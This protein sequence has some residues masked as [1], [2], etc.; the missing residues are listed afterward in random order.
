MATGVELA[1]GWVRVVPT[2]EGITPAI[3]KGLAPAQ[4]I[5]DVEGKKTGKR[6]AGGLTAGIGPA[7][8]AAGVVAGFA[9]LYKIGSI[10]DEVSDT[11]RVGT[12][13]SGAA[14]E[15]LTDV[16]KNVAKTV[17]ASFE[18]A[19]STVADLNTRLGLSGETLQTV[20]SQYL[21]AGRILGEDVD[22]QSTTAAFSAFKIE[23]D[24]VSG[25]MDSLFQVSQ[26]TGVGMNQLASGVQTVAPALQNLGFSFE[27]SIS[28]VGALDKAGL[29]SQQVLA[30]MSKGLVTLARDGEEPQAAFQRVTGEIQS[31]VDQ[32]NEAAALDLASQ[33]F[34]TRGASQFVGAIQSGVVNLADMQGALGATGDTILGVG[35]ET[36]DLAEQWTIFKNR[37]ME[38][39]EPVASAIFGGLG[40]ALG[41]VNQA[42]ANMPP[43]G[44]LFAPVIPILS[45]LWQA[46]QPVV[47]AFM[48][49]GQTIWSALAPAFQQMWAAVSPL[50]PQLVQLWTTVSP[51]ML[52]FRALEPL[53]PQIA[54]LFGQIAGV[55][56]GALGQILPIVV[57]LV[58]TLGNVL[59]EVFAQ[60]IP[61]VS[62]LLST[63]VPVFASIV[64]AILPVVSTII[65]ILAPVLGIVIEILGQVVAFILPILVPVIQLLGGIFSAVF[66]AIGAI[67]EWL[68]N[69]IGKPIFDAIAGVLNWIAKDVLGGFG[70]DWDKIMKGVSAVLGWL[71]NSVIKP[72]FDGIGV[73]FKWIWT[74]VIQPVIGFIQQALTNWGIVV[75]TVGKAVGKVWEGIGT[76]F[77]T[78]RDI[79]S[80]VINHVT[81]VVNNVRKTFED[82]VKGIKDA[83][84]GIGKFI[85]DA[86]GPIAD[87]LGGVGKAVSSFFGGMGDK[88]R[89]FKGRLKDAASQT[90]SLG[91]PGPGTALARVKATLPTGLRI[92]DTLSSPARDR[93]LGLPRSANSYH[94]DA[95]NPA[96]DIAG[97]VP[98]L[99]QYAARLRAM[100]GWR[101]FLWQVAGHYDHIHVAHSGGMVSANWYRSPGD[102]WDE[103][104]VRTQVGETI[105]PKGVSPV[106]V[107]AYIPDDG[108]AG[109][110]RTVLFRVGEREFVGYMEEVADSR[111]DAH[112]QERARQ[113]G[114]GYEIRRG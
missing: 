15:G 109:G 85:K 82:V 69:S 97:P 80:G 63:L 113:I 12:G 106:Q 47:Q 71:W 5:A 23:G 79:I 77:N 53:L 76:V 33:I 65:S 34:G 19:G 92:T 95:K 37:A 49:A 56:G 29:N 2:V 99:H 55:L 103:R 93:A 44:E 81:K 73:I 90:P 84:R 21:E 61:I 46:L 114:R 31:F 42:L 40:T 112:E 107:S 102:K 14:L 101:Q 27:E 32:G 66:T 30:G 48:E 45:N 8:L 67:I 13:A 3:T 64:Q 87:F 51:V 83:F 39:I 59:G 89:H 38:A 100:G 11:I 105:L 4:S 70:L 98:L 28:L 6:F 91:N 22:I 60:I 58:T 26:A 108:P 78:V 86:F 94:Y 104:T 88:A 54:S 9:G 96:V 72:I 74:S 7:A 25:A 50:I 52:I 1:T 24:A 35:A 57:D 18:A 75:D 41:W 10:F 62:N 110:A 16:A 17:P 36:M 111:V 43:M 20:A 68:W